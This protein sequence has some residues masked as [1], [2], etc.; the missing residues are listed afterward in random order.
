MGST[1]TI[2]IRPHFI[3]YPHGFASPILTLQIK[4]QTLYPWRTIALRFEIG[5]LCGGE[6]HQ[7][8]IPVATSLDWAEDHGVVKRY[9]D[10]VVSL[11]NSF[12]FDG[13]SV[14]IQSDADFSG[15]SSA[16]V[17]PAARSQRRW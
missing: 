15:S 6:V 13:C 4:N 17:Q 14:G 16:R 8:S 11:M 9:S 2:L 1:G 10:D 3:D 12:N 7:W 5:A